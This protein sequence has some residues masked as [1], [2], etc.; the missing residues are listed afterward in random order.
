MREQNVNAIHGVRLNPHEHAAQVLTAE[1]LTMTAPSAKGA[2][3][4]RY[5]DSTP[6]VVFSGHAPGQPRE[7]H[8]SHH[9]RDEVGPG[10]GPAGGEALRVLL[11][12]CDHE[13]QERAEARAIEIGEDAAEAEGAVE[14][15]AEEADQ[16]RVEEEIAVRRPSQADRATTTPPAP[17]SPSR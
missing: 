6:S 4:A 14:E 10:R 1:E 3:S 8:H 5:R 17:S 9:I 7:E 11:D 13:H 16:D 2:P 12:S 15:A